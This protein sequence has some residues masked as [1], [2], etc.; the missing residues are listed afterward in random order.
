MVKHKSIPF[1]IESTEKMLYYNIQHLREIP[2]QTVRE[3][4]KIQLKKIGNEE[5][6]HFGG[7]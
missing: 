2:A 4:G 3:G 5:K 6:C 7:K 1:M